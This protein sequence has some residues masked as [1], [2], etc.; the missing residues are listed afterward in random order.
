MEEC[1]NGKATYEVLASKGYCVGVVSAT[2]KQSAL[3]RQWWACALVGKPTGTFLG[4]VCAI[5]DEKH[6][7]RVQGTDLDVAFYEALRRA[8]AAQPPF[9]ANQILHPHGVDPLQPSGGE[10][11]I[12]T[13]NIDGGWYKLRLRALAL[14]RKY[15]SAFWAVSHIGLSD[16]QA[17]EASA[18][19]PVAGWTSVHGIQ[20]TQS[21]SASARPLFEPQRGTRRDGVALGI[22]HR[23]T[24]FYHVHP[25]P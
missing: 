5:A 13:T 1:Q 24:T 17:A 16:F 20:C 3:K 8:P 19:P 22:S 23:T 21:S 11:Y 14:L 7:Y 9:I 12:L 4:V 25:I 2:T 18:A 10:Q 15:R 6:A